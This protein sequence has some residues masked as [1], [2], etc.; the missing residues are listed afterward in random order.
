MNNLEGGIL[1][2][3]QHSNHVPRNPLRVITVTGNGKIDAAPNYAQIQVEV[4]TEGN[5]VMTST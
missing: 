3:Y 1:V 4:I 5:D 2:Y